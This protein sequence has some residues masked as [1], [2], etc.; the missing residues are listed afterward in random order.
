MRSRSVAI[1]LATRVGPLKTL[2]HATICLPAREEI[3]RRLDVLRSVTAVRRLIAFAATATRVARWYAD[4]SQGHRLDSRATV[5][6]SY[7]L[8]ALPIGLALARI[9]RP[10]LVVP[11]PGG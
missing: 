7:W 1:A 11:G 10:P 8:D 9:R 2:R 5:L 6:Y 3:G 4:F